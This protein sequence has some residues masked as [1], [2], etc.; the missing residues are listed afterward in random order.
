MCLAIP[1]KIISINNG[2]AI[3]DYATEKRE[4]IAKGIHVKKGDYVL[5]QFGMV[6]E[7]LPKKEARQ[8]IKNWKTM[9]SP[10]R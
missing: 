7:K 3:V 10:P 4:A 8:A 6:I 5:V 2:K 9:H 1:G